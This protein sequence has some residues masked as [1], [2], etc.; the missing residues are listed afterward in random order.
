MEETPVADLV[1]GVAASVSGSKPSD[2]VATM[3][4]SKVAGLAG[5]GTA[6][7]GLAFF[8]GGAARM[9]VGMGVGVGVV[10]V[11]LGL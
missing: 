9:G 2:V 11:V 6:T 8:T 4:V 5:T 10:G 1:P 3:S 7:G